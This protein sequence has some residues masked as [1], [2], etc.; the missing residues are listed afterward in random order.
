MSKSS[1]KPTVL[2]V[3]P[4]RLRNL[5][6]VS[7]LG[8]L[9]P[10]RKFRVVSLVPDEAE[11]WIH[12]DGKCRMI[13]YNVGGESVADP[14]HLTRINTM[15]ARAAEVPLVIFSD[16]IS[17]DEVVSALN[18]GAR[19]FLYAGT[20]VHLA[21]QA[22][23]FIL[24]RGSYFPPFQAPRGR[25][26]PPSLAIVNDSRAEAAPSADPAGAGEDLIAAPSMNID[27]SGRQK[28]VLERIGRGDSNKAIARRL[29]IREA[30]VKVHVQ[31]IMR[32]LGVVNRTQLAIARAGRG[33]VGGPPDGQRQEHDEVK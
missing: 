28:A 3:D 32:K 13:I 10:S 15:Q 6:L 7:V 27:L 22:L 2:I 25:S 18:A 11:R 1:E 31:R 20:D 14:R 24:E 21:R 23:S 26:P 17:R 12:G 33:N 16:N 5:G 30:T 19:G 4:L 29:G 9:V 8:R